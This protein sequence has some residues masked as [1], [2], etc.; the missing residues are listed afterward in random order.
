MESNTAHYIKKSINLILHINRGQLITL[1]KKQLFLQNNPLNEINR[2]ALLQTP[3]ARKLL[4]EQKA[5]MIISKDPSFNK[6]I[7]SADQFQNKL[8]CDKV[9]MN[10]F[11]RQCSAQ[12][13]YAISDLINNLQ[14]NAN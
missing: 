13:I 14:S 7:K 10:Y 1:I 12:L 5:L 3:A 9:R 8:V 4:N 6:K 2:L 11:N